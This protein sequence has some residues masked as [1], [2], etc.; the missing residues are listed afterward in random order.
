ME[1]TARRARNDDLPMLVSLY[2]QLEAEMTT[3][4]PMW[5]LA[6]GLPEPVDLAFSDALAD[7]DTMIY[8]GLIDGYPLGFLIARVEDLLPQAKGEQVGSI[9][10]VFVDADAREV[11][12]GES[13]RDMA[14]GE[15]RA[16]GLR[17][18]D[19]HVLPGHRLVKNF[20]EAGGF[21]ARSIVMHHAD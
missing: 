14:L 12:I 4:H 11:G 9:R 3:L 16:R 2:G 1:V 13:M 21:S 19:A 20:F 17:R 8:L 15:L 10:L 7:G 18:F 6:D 5:P